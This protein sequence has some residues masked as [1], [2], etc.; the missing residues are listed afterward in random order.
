MVTDDLPTPQPP[1]RPTLLP[2]PK[3]SI[4]TVN[5]P[6]TGDD[7]LG[8]VLMNEH[9]VCDATKKKRNQQSSA[10]LASASDNSASNDTY[11]TLANLSKIRSNPFDS[12]VNMTLSSMNDI[13]DE[14]KQVQVDSTTASTTTATTIL[15]I[16]SESN[17]RD[18][19]SCQKLSKQLGGGNVNIII[20][21]TPTGMRSSG[22]S[23]GGIG[24][25]SASGSG[26]N[27]DQDMKSMIEEDITT[28]EKELMYGIDGYDGSEEDDANDP[29]KGQPPNIIRAG[30]VGEIT[31]ELFDSSKNIKTSLTPEEVYQVKAC[32]IV[33]GTTSAPLIVGLSASAAA[34][35]AASASESSSTISTSV[36]MTASSS[37][38]QKH[39]VL[40][41]LDL[42]KECGCKLS[43]VVISHIDILYS[44]VPMIKQ[45]LDQ[46]ANVCFDSYGLS[47][48]MHDL[49]GIYPNIP[50][51]VSC[52]SNLLSCN[53]NYVYQ[54]VLSCGI[55]M[56]LQYT[57]YGG[58]GYNILW[59]HLI[60]KLL[61]DGAMTRHQ[62]HI[63]FHNNPQRLLQF[64]KEPPKREKPKVYM[65]CS[66]CNEK[67]E[68]IEGKYY[69]KYKFV[70]CSRPCLLKH[71]NN[72]FK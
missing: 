33:S 19:L 62:L 52:L 70:Y 7:D 25:E 48:A 11:I 56:K 24:P 23:N 34:T 68:P 8:R 46:S 1:S 71:I 38:S 59:K 41:I 36:A 10:M 44:N 72:N 35:A 21:T 51:V 3:C 54:I 2:D 65:D 57:K 31:V 66:V 40:Q 61:Q 17:G 64:W 14:Y 22:G 43:N 50:S 60:P 27:G 37:S 67:F 53:P 9:L 18:P 15:A 39:I 42:I 26:S 45:I 16:T 30:F 5:G 69:S 12:Q 47:Y 13:I 29:K 49:N 63:V 58:L 32:A 6:I 20:G 28:M 55:C 4:M